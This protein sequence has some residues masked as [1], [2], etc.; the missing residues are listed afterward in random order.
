MTM[1]FEN[2]LC[3]VVCHLLPSRAVKAYEALKRDHEWRAWN[4]MYDRDFLKR[5]TPDRRNKQTK[6]SQHNIATTF[7]VALFS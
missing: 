4:R 5:K 7:W 1:F 2:V 3:D 6:D